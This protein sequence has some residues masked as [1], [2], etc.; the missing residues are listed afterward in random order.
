MYCSFFMYPE[1]ENR[2]GMPCMGRKQH[3]SMM[4]NKTANITS[5]MSLARCIAK[6]FSMMLSPQLAGKYFGFHVE[7]AAHEIVSRFFGEALNGTF[8]CLPLQEKQ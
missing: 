7:Y 1:H 8:T 2:S 5:S 3:I 6:C 4:V